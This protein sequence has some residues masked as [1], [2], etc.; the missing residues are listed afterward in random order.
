MLSL[1]SRVPP[2]AGVRVYTEH[3]AR[4]IRIRLHRQ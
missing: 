1:L 2:F 3:N 4:P